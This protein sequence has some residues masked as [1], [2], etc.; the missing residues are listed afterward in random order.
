MSIKF[1]EKNYEIKIFEINILS[2]HL[3]GKKNPTAIVQ[4]IVDHHRSRIKDFKNLGKSLTPIEMG[5]ITYYS[6][7]NE[8]ID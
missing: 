8:S 6:Y 5:P 1:K 4:H 3:I 7:L 2:H